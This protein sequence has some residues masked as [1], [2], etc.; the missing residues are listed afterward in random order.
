MSGGLGYAQILVQRYLKRVGATMNDE[1]PL[2]RQ[3]ILLRTLAAR[4]YGATVKE[5]AQEAGVIADEVGMG[6]TRIAVEVAR[7]VI[8]AG[9][10]VAILVPP[11]LGYLPRLFGPPFPLETAEIDIHQPLPT[12]IESGTCGS[13]EYV[14]IRD[15]PLIAKTRSSPT[16]AA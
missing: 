5:L 12:S 15:L 2:I 6:K 14:V 4:K 9:G 10:R 13:A 8:E 7:S 1:S 16:V 3:W 11:G